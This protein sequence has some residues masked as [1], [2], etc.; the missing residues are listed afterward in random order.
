MWSANELFESKLNA[1]T[2]LERYDSNI[3]T[4]I[5]ID[6]SIAY[7]IG[8]RERNDLLAN[9]CREEQRLFAQIE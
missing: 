1:P 6:V 3:E 9:S 5:R 2:A 8:A 4:S 7:Q